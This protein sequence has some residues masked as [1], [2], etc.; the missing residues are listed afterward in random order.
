MRGWMIVAAAGAA[1]AGCGQRERTSLEVANAWALGAAN[2]LAPPVSCIAR[3]DIAATTTRDDRTVDFALADGR[4]LRNRLPHACPGLARENR[5]TY[6]TALDRVCSVD[7]ITLLRLDGSPGP[8][9]GLGMFQEIAVPPRA[10]PLAA[11][12]AR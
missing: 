12:P 8:T 3:G 1:L 10:P 4:L 2:P 5:F 6:R 11:D 9:C 7:T